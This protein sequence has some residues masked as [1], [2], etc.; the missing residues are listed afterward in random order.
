M[1]GVFGAFACVVAGTWILVWIFAFGPKGL[2][3]ESAAVRRAQREAAH[4]SSV[5][6]LAQV[7]PD[8]HGRERKHIQL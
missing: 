3:V 6:E 5:A 1:E 7:L 2:G 8:Q 4:A